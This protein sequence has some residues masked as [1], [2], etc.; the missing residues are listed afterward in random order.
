MV[1]KEGKGFLVRLLLLLQGPSLPPN[2]LVVVPE[3]AR[4]DVQCWLICGPHN[5]KT[6]F[7]LPLLPLASVFLLNW[8]VDCEGP[9]SVG[10][11]KYHTQQFFSMTVP[12][13]FHYELVHIIEAIAL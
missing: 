2:T 8:R 12:E 1:I 13:S 7:T 6:L 11:L 5:T 3:G 10:G 4:Q 9:S